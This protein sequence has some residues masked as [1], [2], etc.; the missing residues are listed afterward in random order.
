VNKDPAEIC[1]KRV[2]LRA[3]GFCVEVADSLHDGLLR[4]VEV[5]PVDGRAKKK[6]KSAFVEQFL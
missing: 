1:R 4:V 6:L 5:V 3:P 2:D